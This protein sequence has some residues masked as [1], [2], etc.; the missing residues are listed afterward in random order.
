[1]PTDELEAVISAFQHLALHNETH[2]QADQ[3]DPELDLRTKL[4]RLV[5]SARSK[6]KT[7]HDLPDVAL[8]FQCLILSESREWQKVN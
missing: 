5:D 1:M 3:H 6:R 4:H 8:D 2:T 7:H